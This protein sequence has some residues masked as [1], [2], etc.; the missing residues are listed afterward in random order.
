MTADHRVLFI[1]PTSATWES[2]AAEVDADMARLARPGVVLTYR[3]TG[4]GPTDVRTL[5][6]ARAA[7]PFVVQSIVAAAA[8]GFDA[9]IVD[10]TADPGVAEARQ[11]VDIAV[12]G[13]GEAMRSAIAAAKQPVCELTGDDLRGLEIAVLVHTLRKAATVALGGTGFSHLVEILVA[14]KPGVAVLDP[15]D[16][17]LEACLARLTG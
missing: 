13:A 4:A 12:V 7:A 6:D 3:C 1:G 10:C 8:E 14:A 15:L 16:V 2:I 5:H 9:V 17:A 11:L